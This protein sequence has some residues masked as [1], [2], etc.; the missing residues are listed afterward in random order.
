M[1]DEA[2]SPLRHDHVFL[3]AAHDTH[4]RRTRWVV[5]LTAGMMV[6]EIVAGW[7][8]GSMALL[9]DGLHMA[10]HAGALG[11][12]A[13]AYGYAR[14]HAR[15]RRFTFGTGKVGDL[16]GFTSALVLAL[17][18]LGI[19]IESFQRL[20]A[21]AS[22]AYAQALWIAVLGLAVNLASAWLLGGGHHRHDHRADEPDHHHAHGAHDDHNLRSAYVHVLADAVT[23]VLAIV[24]LLAGMYLGWRWMD[25]AM[26]IVGALVIARWSY[27]LLRDTGAVLVDA[28]QNPSLE[29]EIR[30]AIED[31]DARITDL[32]VWR[33]GP[34]RFA[35]I[36]SLVA[37]NPLEA[38]DY[39]ARVR[40]HEELAHITVEVHRCT[41]DHHKELRAA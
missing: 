33:V 35:A 40:I 23:S 34:G 9:A 20:L 6:V 25:S 27:G 15:D 18:A 41:G 16:A 36:I 12:A 29:Q 17:I 8:T 7:L 21:P 39:T 11:V 4:E 10:T 26:G 2:S 37:G 24:A 32:H 1:H 30:E 14:R 28:T 22:I 38:A 3:G 13:L 19:G 5:A 31:G